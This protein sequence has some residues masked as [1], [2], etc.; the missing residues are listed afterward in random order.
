MTSLSLRLF[1]NSTS[2]QK[3][4]KL[5]KSFL[6][7]LAL[8][9]LIFEQLLF[10][11]SASAQ[12][13][14]INPDGTTNT[15]VTQ[16][17][18]GVD[19]VNIAAPNANGL[20]HNKFTDY[21]VN[22]SG[23]VINN[24]SGYDGV[25][26]GSVTGA[27]AV[28]QTQIGGLVTT[29]ANLVNSGSAKVIL[30]EVTSSNTSQLLGYTEIAGTKA[31]LILANPNGI[32]CFGCGFVNTARLLMVA[33]SSNFDSN[34]N[35]GFNLKEQSNPNLYV[36]LITIDGL[37][38]DVSRTSSA[39][40][41]AS[42]IKLLSSIYGSDNT[43]LTLKT[44]E[45]RCD[46][47]SKEIIG[48]TTQNSSQAV[49]AIDAS[50]LARIQSGQVFLI[51]TKH[52]VGVKMEADVLASSTVNIDA[53]GDV[54]Y[55]NISAGDTSNLKSTQ[56][57]QSTDSNSSISAPT[58]NIQA[59][60]FQNLGIASAYN[61]NIQNSGTLTNLGD[62]EALSLN[63]S[64]ITDINNSGSLY[65]ENSL[66]ISSVN[67]TNNSAGS[68]FSP[69]SYSIALT[70]L[71]TNS[72]IISSDG[73]LGIT[74]NQLL[75]NAG[76]EIS[77]ATN[78]TFLITDS[79]TSSGNLIAGRV[80]NFSANALSNSGA[81]Q[82][83]DDANFNL[84]TL[85]NSE[86]SSIYSAKILT[87]NLS[88]S[89]TNS[90]EISSLSNLVI[91]G[92]SS[93]TNSGQILSNSGLSIVGNNL[94]N[95]SSG[96]IAS[97]TASLTLALSNNLQNDGEFDS[98]T[99]LTA[100]A[101]N[102]SNSGNILGNSNLILNTTSLTNSGN[103]QS[104][105]DTTINSSSLDNSGLIKSFAQ[106]T[107]NAD[108]ITNQA[109]ALIFTNDDLTINVNS[110]GLNN[111][112]AISS[113]N[114]FTLNSS[115]GSNSN[116]GVI[117]S[118]NSFVI[119]GNNDFTNS[120][121]LYSDDI[122]S[123]AAA[124][125][126]NT[127]SG[128]IFSTKDTSLTFSDS[129]TNSGNLQATTNLNLNI[130]GSTNNSGSIVGNQLAF[131]NTGD[132]SNSGSIASENDLTLSAANLTN[133]GML[134]SVGTSTITLV[135]SLTTQ[136]NSLIY[137]GQTLALT[138]NTS[139]TNAGEIS[140]ID[141][142]LLT[143]S[144]LTNSGSILTNNALTINGSSIDNEAN[145]TIASINK[146]LTLNLSDQL[147]NAG[148]IFAKENLTL[149][150]LTDNSA[151]NSV[152]NSGDISFDLLVDGLKVKSL[153]NSGNISSAQDLTIT[154]SNNFDNSGNVSSQD[155]LTINSQNI[156]SNSGT[157]L[158]SQNLNLTTDSITNDGEISALN[159]I[160][161]ANAGDVTNSS[162]IL[163]NGTLSITATNLTN[164]DNA[165][166]ASLANS[167][168]LTLTNNLQN[169][170]ELF[171]YDNLA[172]SSKNFT[173][174]GDVLG[175]NNLTVSATNSITNSGNFQSTNDS[176]LTAA[177]L[178]NSGT[179]KSF[180]QSAINADSIANQLDALIV[181]DGDLTINSNIG[182]LNN[183]GA[184]S[185][186]NNFIFTSSTLT[187]SGTIYSKNNFSAT[188]SSDFTNSGTLY[189]DGNFLLSASSISNTSSSWIF[190]TKD[191][192]LTSLLNFTNAG[193]LQATTD[194][195]LTVGGNSNNSGSI[196]G[197]QLTFT[198]TGDITNSG[199]IASENDLS[200]SSTNLTNSG[201]I[202][203]LGDAKIDLSGNL[204]NQTN[205]AIYSGE[206]L[207]IAASGSL[208]NAGE[209]SATT[210]ATFNFSS[211]TNSS[212]I[213]ANNNLTIN[214]A[215]IDNQSNGTIASINDS[216]SFNL[217][218]YLTNS[219][220]I[221]AKENLTLS[222]LTNDS[223]L[224]SVDN[225]GDI[226]FNKFANTNNELKV[227]S[228]TNSGS[229][230]SGSST[231]DLLLTASDKFD[232]SGSISSQKNFT[233]NSQNIF[234]NSGTI[235][236]NQN[237]ILG[238][239]SITNSGEI[240]AL[241]NLTITNLGDVTNSGNILS[242]G[243]LNISASNL[244]N[245]LN[246]AIASL[247]SSLTLTLSNNLQNSGEL[248]STTNLG[249]TNKSFTNSGDVLSGNNLTV[250]TTNSITNS[251]NIQSTGDSSLTSTSLENS[252]SI[253][254]FG[255]S[256]IN[257][258]TIDNQTNALIFSNSDVSIT[259]NSSLT[260]AGSI[261]SNTKL[262]ITSGSTNISGEIF[263]SDNLTLTL[264]AL[265]TNSGSISSQG[266]I[267]VSSTSTITNS[268]QIQSD[269]DLSVTLG[270]DLS[271]SGRIQS[272]ENGAFNLT[273]FSNSGS[274][275][276]DGDL[277]L[278][279]TNSLNNSG[280]IYSSG[281]QQLTSNNL[282]N[283]SLI[284]AGND[285]TIASAIINNSNTKPADQN[286]ISSGIVSDAGSI[287]F[288]TNSINNNSGLI[289]GS[290][291]KLN[292]LSVATNQL[293]S[294]GSLL[295][296]SAILTSTSNQ[297]SLLNDLGS[298]TSGS[299]F[300]NL[301]N[302]D[303]TIT[304]TTTT[305][306]L[307]IIANNITNL[308]NVTASDY[309]KLTA[310]GS[311]SS[312][313]GSITN[314][315]AT[316]N[317]ANIQLAAGSYLNLTANSSISN[318]GTISA[319]TDATITS[320][321][322][323]ITNYGTGKIKGGSGTA[324]VNA[325]NGTF[326][327][328]SSTSL[329]TANN[330]A[331][332]NT[333][334]LINSGEISVGH[335][336]T[337]NEKY[338][339]GS[340][341]SADSFCIA[342]AVTP[343]GSLFNK[344][345]ALI[346]SG[347]N[348]TFNVGGYFDNY[349]Q[350]SIYA[351]NN[352]T[353]QA[354]NSSDST[355]N[356]TSIISNYGNIS[357]YIGD[358]TLI[359]GR[360]T[361]N[362]S[363]EINAAGNFYL[364]ANMLVSISASIISSGDM[365]IKA[366]AVEIKGVTTPNIIKSGGSMTI[367]Q[368]GAGAYFNA[369]S[370]NIIAQHTQTTKAGVKSHSSTTVNGIDSYT[371]SETGVI[372]VDLSSIVS[373]ISGHNSVET[374]SS[375]NLSN[376]S[377]SSGTSVSITN[378]GIGKV[379]VTNPSASVDDAS[380][381][382]SKFGISQSTSDV[383]VKAIS[384]QT[385]SKN[386]VSNPTAS[387][388]GSSISSSDTSINS[389]SLS[390]ATPN[391]AFS[392]NFK[393]NLDSSAST[394]LVE[395]RSQFTDVSKFFGS[396]YY[397]N[398]LGL[399]GSAV[400]ADIDR[401]TRNA[402]T[403]RM[404]GD[405]FVETKLI[406]DQLKKLTNDSLFLSKNTTDSNQQ[407]KEL[408]DNSIA[409]FARLGL[410]A[411]DVAING[412]TTTQ[413]NSLTK[414][415]VTFETTKVNGISVLAPKIYLS[416]TTRNRLLGS[417][418]S[419]A[420][421]STIFA[422][423]DLT[424]D[425][426][427]SSFT[428]YGDIASGNNLIL[429][430]G[431]L[432][433]SSGKTKSGN[434]LYVTAAGDIT[435]NASVSSL[436]TLSM[437]SLN[438]NILN[439]NSGKISSVGDLAISATGGSLTNSSA[440]IS[441]NND[442]FINAK[443][444][445]NQLGN[446]SSSNDLT[447][448][449]TKDIKN[450]AASIS[451]TN[452][453]NLITTEGS[454][455]N[456][457]LV[458]TNDA[459]LLKLNSD[460]YQLTA[461]AQARASG[462][463]SSSLISSIATLSGGNINISAAQDFNNLGA[464]IQTL[465]NT[466]TDG[467]ATVGDLSIYAGANVNVQDL[468][469]HNRTEQSWAM[470]RGKR[471]S[472]RVNV[473][474]SVTTV[475]SGFAT[476][477][478]ISIASGNNI[479]LQNLSL[480]SENISLNSN[481]QINLQDT[482]LSSQD[483]LSLNALGDIKIYNSKPLT[484]STSFA[485]SAL[486]LKDDASTARSNATF[487]ATSDI[488]INS[489]GSI[490]IT[491]NYLNTGGSIFMSAANDINNSNY[492]IKASDNVVMS[493]TNIN[494]I[495][496]IPSIS[497]NSNET[498]IE[499]GNMVSLD[500]TNDINNIGATIK[501]GSLVYLTAGHNINNQA[502]VKY[503]INGI[504]TNS[505]G[506]AITE[507]QALASDARYISSGLVS[508]GSITSGGNLVMV[509]A[510][511]INNKGS[512]ITSTGSS[513]LEATNGN[514]NVTTAALRDKTF[515]E[516]GKK[517]KHWV[518]ITDNISNIQS[519]ITSGGSL[520]LVASG[521]TP[522]S[523]A[524]ASEIGNINITGSKLS[525]AD[526]LTLQAKNDIT[527]QSAQNSSYAF[528]AGRTGR[529]KSYLNKSSST[530]QVES[531][532]TTTNNGDIIISSGVGNADT[533]GATGS[534]GSL[535]IIA[536]NLTTKDI[537]GNSSNNAGS[538]NIT[539]TTKEDLVIASAL[540]STY[541]EKSSS[542]KGGSTKT[543][544][545]NIDSEKNNISSDIA[546][547]GDITTTSGNSTYIIASNLTGEG[548][549]K[550]TAGKYTDPSNS[551]N[552]TYNE[553]ATL[554]IVSATDEKFHYA[555][556]QKISTDF[557]A[558]AVGV[559]AAVAVTAAT[560]GAGAMAMAGASG[561]MIGAGAKKTKTTT[562]LAYDAT[563]K[564]SE[565]TFNNSLTVS[566]GSDTNITSSNL[567]ADSITIN[568]GKI[569]DENGDLQTINENANLNIATIADVHT[570]ESSTKKT[571]ANYL[572]VAVTSAA[573]AGMSMAVGGF[574]GAG[575]SAIGT[576]V[577]GQAAGQALGNAMFYAAMAGTSLSMVNGASAAS[578]ERSSSSTSQTTL[579]QAASNLNTTNNLNLLSTKNL[580]ISASN[581]QTSSTSGSI[582]LTSE[583]GDTNLLAGINSSTTSTSSENRNFDSI[584]FSNTHSSVGMDFT[585]TGGSDTTTITQTSLAASNLVS[586]NNININS[587]SLLTTSDASGSAN[588]LASNLSADNQ[589][590]IIT[591]NELNIKSGEEITDILTSHSDITNTITLSVGN[592]W[593]GLADSTVQSARSVE[594]SNSSQTDDKAKAANA[595][596]ASA[597]IGMNALQA[598]ITA[599]SYGFYGAATDT[600]SRTT[601]DSNSNY[602]TNAASNLYATNDIT[603]VSNDDLTVKGSNIIS[604]SGD[605]NLRSKEGNVNIIA[606][607]NSATSNSSSETNSI[608][609]TV[610]ISGG[611]VFVSIPT[612]TSSRSS[613][614]Y[615]ATSYQSSN[616]N[617][618]NGTININT[619]DDTNVIGSSL[620]AKD[621]SI[622]TTNLNVESLQSRLSSH[623][624][625]DSYSLGGNIGFNNS[626]QN[627]DRLWTDN[628]ASIIGTNSV[629]INATEN[630]NLVGGVIANSTNG[631][632]GADAIDGE[633][634][635]INTKTLTYSNLND[636]NNSDSS[637]MGLTIGIPV[638]VGA[639]P[640][641][642]AFTANPRN[643]NISFNYAANETNQEQITKATIGAGTI[644]L[645]STIAR[646]S[647]TGEVTS[648]AGSETIAQNDSRISGLN[649]DITN[650]QE[651]TRDHTEGGYNINLNINLAIAAEA[652][653]LFSQEGRD[654]LGNQ[655][656]K[657]LGGTAKLYG[658]VIEQSGLIPT[659]NNNG[660]IYQQMVAMVTGDQT[661]IGAEISDEA[662]YRVALANSRKEEYNVIATDNGETKL[663][664]DTGESYLINITKTDIDDYSLGMKNQIQNGVASNEFS[665]INDLKLN[666]DNS[667]NGVNNTENEAILKGLRTI[668]VLQ[669]N[670]LNVIYDP[671]HGLFPDTLEV[672]W[673]KLTGNTVLQSG[674]LYELNS[675]AQS[676]SQAA[677][678]NNITDLRYVG[679]SGGGERLYDGI[680]LGVERGSLGYVD[681]LQQQ[682]SRLQTQF[683]GTP[684]KTTSL[685]E[686]VWY[687]TGI[688]DNN[689]Q[690]QINPND[691]VAENLG[692]NSP[693]TSDKILGAF[694]PGIV[695]VPSLFDT[696]T[697]PHST[698]FCR[699][700]FCGYEK[701][702]INVNPSNN[703]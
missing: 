186:Q 357:T 539:L 207:N 502:L 334:D 303:Y 440:T 398:A 251:G 158:S 156:F 419:L 81:I 605:I 631:S 318:Y 613:S 671:T 122:L 610:S 602:V 144:S 405:A 173:N 529:G 20:S 78:L 641:G 58:V 406:L 114:N 229:F 510:N 522:S 226:S 415:V 152:N 485:I 309:I 264:T 597:Q 508:Q 239:D 607:A 630:T 585:Q 660:G 454:I 574:A 627:Q 617:A 74:A 46:Y 625:S 277:L 530:T 202:Q 487:N 221:F 444:V 422:K 386:N 157:I 593:L 655:A 216:L 535:A 538:G 165:A 203:D 458:T 664:F 107:I 441:S 430:V 17:A 428:N 31:D 290:S 227:K 336:L 25:A 347:N 514:I 652:K 248:S 260:N 117:Y 573:V 588:I 670:T 366:P 486:G 414:D 554:N 92:A 445:K 439:Q 223:A 559:I 517:K 154:S 484:T 659:E 40:I 700:S 418:G 48:D 6:V 447:I 185:S 474:D 531:D 148:T 578:T 417:A 33:G 505:D 195:D 575:G 563:Q 696:K 465:K 478:E 388:D 213:L 409:E 674:N 211:V 495:H 477:G 504:S 354:N 176:F 703:Q 345:S 493:A 586:A 180:G 246:S 183:A 189:S 501:G 87:L 392:G 204:I 91:T 645:S 492:T 403:T 101:Q 123:I 139:L 632:I 124:N 287:N 201:L 601:T 110:G 26:A 560:G 513:Y 102:F 244:T 214:S 47:N 455:F 537:D 308:G 576:A 443:D 612:I 163:S 84:A 57:I 650:T 51:A 646:D 434:N 322:G 400:L 684:T 569:S 23:Q 572:A 140:A 274:L 411:E 94:S 316:G 611:G 615:S 22:T 73:N 332:F 261:L 56:K 328:Y 629:T 412:L 119:L 167:L 95:G 160:T 359:T 59:N 168:T 648:I 515:A 642:M 161:I 329:F 67:L 379:V 432:T 96:I 13:L 541:E 633:N 692:R 4:L 686:A 365:L 29:N 520:D 143:S 326:T 259:S 526:N 187:N 555:M 639:T 319:T 389:S 43:T 344:Q 320:T 697:S 470:G 12:A 235:L 453:L 310:T 54:Y 556:T 473:S 558:V 413:A 542:K 500:A 584:G 280:T 296:I 431:S 448:L 9:S 77:A 511:D 115:N 362:S 469:Q 150:N 237:L 83:D 136:E 121:T 682:Q 284:F 142:A 200:L 19:Q 536:S 433:N 656:A 307:E 76:S 667:L 341:C 532:L 1:H 118:A 297:V 482:L 677:S 164:S 300:L 653:N 276:T 90:G 130:G 231:Q 547:T 464:K 669:S 323:G 624:E 45:G 356:K 681:T 503:T 34:G 50:S 621:I 635:T 426:A 603:L 28:T 301:G 265:L 179:I 368:S 5:S 62:I 425:A 665:L 2:S 145:G 270:G 16:T 100:S 116:S 196:L 543:T 488:E 410:N 208:N 678:T 396:A 381:N 423:D 217:S 506:S 133:S 247:T 424:I 361:A 190:S 449:A 456:T 528:S 380:I 577:A 311:G 385:V 637:S 128:W 687:A 595:T 30:N 407:I 129:F 592:A 416:Q 339:S 38:L 293:A 289:T 395:A 483:K 249:L 266:K 694:G 521:T 253:K 463:I 679:H 11:A 494:N 397:F 72:G 138:A 421:S 35:L 375:L 571:H 275:L 279:T 476:A 562:E 170:G 112:G 103:L 620:L 267:T 108:T 549:G 564:S 228:F 135:N 566:S 255:Q 333:K 151:L 548:S 162:K 649:R 295:T 609:E 408:L 8:I 370:N 269:K 374:G 527:I 198:N 285:L 224:N 567:T 342:I 626:E 315:S 127:Y 105:N 250:S 594:Q 540:N 507:S 335:D 299:I 258:A 534:K 199:S 14:P 451:A 460:S 680:L 525:S 27:N 467:S 583:R 452:N 390:A 636:Y 472:H 654:Y 111:A 466:L 298:L 695:H 64:N 640:G 188:N 450:I 3:I 288:F 606:A 352:L 146:S 661:I 191:T 401:Q 676:V 159:N 182:G 166:I 220:T 516:G 523:S 391:V 644:N 98:V 604:E 551:S 468:T 587:G 490:N 245:N 647:T 376:A 363:S 10:V 475:S 533:I 371:L 373:A 197:N 691:Y 263:S 113:Q 256:T 24:F 222:N 88:D 66:S 591:N 553:N 346:W 666:K 262:N 52:G 313:S 481:N 394:P 209:I 372:D 387:V 427:N 70:G 512:T 461:G 80:L 69:Q 71:L 628:V 429:N 79:A 622:T 219:G 393:I 480:N 350:A 304:G 497:G 519:S 499:A 273:N 491:N 668:G 479:N 302:T 252:G 147:T 324:T 120:G 608:S 243:T 134:Q 377:E 155:N 238:T 355:Q 18:A 702:G 306:D 305:D 367:V 286:S 86:N 193:N 225:S 688:K 233:I 242:N 546:A 321:N 561:A 672:G 685:L 232:N 689:T 141:S 699:G 614:D 60:E 169:S 459:N 651:I 446:I 82:S 172:T 435:N 340:S 327:N 360:M 153:T 271:N 21:N 42:S 351:N 524:L 643:T 137:S 131:S 97:L 358:V 106:A 600:F 580:N 384:G 181:S 109:D 218:D 436:G 210:S 582:N 457:A 545:L 498:R 184:I 634:L 496:T 618:T 568:A 550:L 36:P 89:L 378:H 331:I 294:D 104:A 53:N 420:Q 383:S 192:S 364:D 268:G 690:H 215:S 206:T 599:P 590:N 349:A 657:N 369:G 282:T 75:N 509:A 518:S 557:T 32:T 404:L 683:Y 462:N 589:I 616:L 579:T 41:I 325:L 544:K 623:S 330:D 257:I 283:S 619:K 177:S 125:F 570:R 399:N 693:N 63:L 701:L 39:D 638:G 662:K 85:A 438:G 240:S 175:E 565:L 675:Y 343:H 338:S 312:Q 65:G 55:S 234:I 663:V 471:A 93:I 337:V 15:Q 236:A 132:I 281:D 581:L 178:D 49:F 174:S 317:N 353:V 291:I 254:S 278:K 489:L 314:G 171:S 230:V 99:D 292:P 126:T 241:N 442:L 205:S 437:S 348:A 552:I 194:L 149:A 68:I 598:I 37:G 212:N 382:T 673:N 658:E 698:Y 7:H 44:G 272:N 596:A 402:T 61:L